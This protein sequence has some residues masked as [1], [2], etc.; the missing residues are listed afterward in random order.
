M[1]LVEN[2]TRFVG[3]PKAKKTGRGLS[4]CIWAYGRKSPS[5]L[6]LKGELNCDRPQERKRLLR[7]YAY[8]L[9][10]KKGE[11]NS[12]KRGD[13]L[14]ESRRKKNKKGAGVEISRSRSEIHK[15]ASVHKVICA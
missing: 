7:K 14:E 13:H 10:P 3:E 9:W 2:A 5:R 4:L 1:R 6:T 11:L 15:L 8:K 12:L